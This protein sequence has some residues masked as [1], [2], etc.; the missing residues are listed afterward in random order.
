MN[1]NIFAAAA[2]AACA[3]AASAQS[4]VTIYGTVDAGLVHEGGGAF[5]TVNKVTS[6]VG[7]YSRLGFRGKEDLGG[8]LAGIFTLESGFRVDTGE[9]AEAGSLFN[10]QA[11]VG[12]QSPFGTLTLGRQNTPYHNLLV[13]VADPFGTG[14]AGTS[15]NLFPDW[16]TNVR[17]S[18]VIM[19]TAPETMGFTGDV[20]YS[21]GEQVGSNTAG[22]Q[23][24]ASVGYAWGPLNVRFAYNNKDSNIAAAP[25]VPAVTRGV[26][27]NKLLAA[28][29]DFQVVKAYVAYGVDQGFN[30]SP[31][32]NINNPFGLAVAPTP[33]TDSNEWLVGLTAQLGTGS[34]MASFMHKNDKT[35]F[36]QDARAWG[37]GYLYPLSK[38]THLYTAY[39]H[40]TNKNGAGYT[41][42]NNTEAGSGNRAFNLGVRHS[43]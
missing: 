20:M 21:P 34:L 6:G 4:G 19:Y 32:G 22:R 25:G 39:G 9:Q 29:W 18:N 10:R 8:G 7:T 14:F 28:N 33:S 38:R 23:T 1:K 41:V 2:L 42:A 36:N 17:A 16:G 31:L 11:F 35:A 15:R 27:T 24:G 12:L 5:G 30:S 26:G 3:G 13:Q 43:F 37:V 40:I